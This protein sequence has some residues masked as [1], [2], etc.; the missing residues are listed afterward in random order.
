[1]IAPSIQNRTRPIATASDANRARNSAHRA[2][3]ASTRVNVV[4]TAENAALAEA[5]FYKRR[6][7]LPAISPNEPLRSLRFRR[8]R[9]PRRRG[10]AA[11]G[12][13]RDTPANVRGDTAD[14][15][16][17]IAVQVARRWPWRCRR[18]AHPA[19]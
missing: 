1:M 16:S 15:E 3:R 11:S 19:G 2:T 6:V 12:I 8:F 4:S 13:R 18:L 14:D 7:Q 17:P 5:Y 10:V 9:S